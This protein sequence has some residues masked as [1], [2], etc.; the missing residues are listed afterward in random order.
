M[1]SKEI[2]QCGFLLRLKRF[3]YGG[4]SVGTGYLLHCFHNR[5]NCLLCI[6]H[7]HDVNSTEE[8]ECGFGELIAYHNVAVCAII[9]KHCT[10]LELSRNVEQIRDSLKG[11]P[12]SG[13]G[14]SGCAPAMDIELKD[15]DPCALPVAATHGYKE[16][17]L[18]PVI[19]LLMKLLGKLPSG[20]E[21]LSLGAFKEGF[22]AFPAVCALEPSR[23]AGPIGCGTSEETG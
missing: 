23:G 16:A 12:T 2:L 6:G 8:V 4:S 3:D 11:R 5:C 13:A 15:G 14:H 7:L 20:V 18:S 1:S 19:H 10:L 17:V 9:T 22:K 21:E